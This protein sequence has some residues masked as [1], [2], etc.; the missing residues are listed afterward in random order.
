MD[1]ILLDEFC[2][3]GKRHVS[4]E[5]SW[6]TIH[7]VFL[8]Y[9]P[10]NGRF[11]LSL[12]LLRALFNLSTEWMEIYR[13]RNS[14]WYH[15]R[16]IVLAQKLYLHTRTTCVRALLLLLLRERG[17]ALE[18]GGEYTCYLVYCQLVIFSVPVCIGKVV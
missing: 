14:L 8:F 6:M 7:S 10:N 13:R 9:G 5:A 4:G 16:W 2:G 15:F 17:R 18:H 3:L 1:T 11:Q 12:S